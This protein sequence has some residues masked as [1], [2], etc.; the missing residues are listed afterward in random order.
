M[1]KM[2]LRSVAAIGAV[3]ALISPSFAAADMPCLLMCGFSVSGKHGPFL[4]QFDQAKLDADRAVA[5][6]AD[7]IARNQQTSKGLGAASIQRGEFYGE[8]LYMPRTQARLETVI[9]GLR[10]RWPYRD[11]GPVTVH[12]VGSTNFAP[13]ARPDNSIV[14]PLGFLVRSTTDDEVAWV[15]AHEYSHIAL[16][17]F[18][19][20][21]ELARRQREVDGF[22]NVLLLGLAL[23]QE[24]VDSTGQGVHF[25]AVNDPKVAKTSSEL[26]SKQLTVRT[27]LDLRSQ[28]VSRDQEDQA[29]ASGVDLAMGAGYAADDGSAHALDMIAADDARVGGVLQGLQSDL[30]KS[31]SQSISAQAINAAKSGN[32]GAAGEDFFNNLKANI[33]TIVGQKLIEYLSSSHRP[34]ESR[35]KGLGAYLTAA[36][37]NTPDVSEKTT[38][39][40]AVRADTEYVTAK[41][42]VE[43]HDQS[44]ID[45]DAGDAQKALSDL[46]AARRT[47]YAATPYVDDQAA[48]IYAALGDV[49]AADRLYNEA[50]SATPTRVATA[51]AGR[52]HSRHAGAGAGNAR[53]GYQPPRDIFLQ[54]SLV[55]Y[56]LHVALLAAHGSYDQARI[57]IAEAE[58]HFGDHQMFLPDLIYIDLKQGH[59]DDMLAAFDECHDTE[60]EILI[61]KCRYAIMD[62][63]T[64]K[65]VA[66]LSPA[67]RAKVDRALEHQDSELG[68]AGFMS[69]LKSVGSFV[70]PAKKA[71][72]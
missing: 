47:P 52:S 63:D 70:D 25:Y 9:A 31:M 23:S 41:T 15:L 10:A 50:E 4:K 24:R 62:E 35:R 29:D 67:E 13:L 8:G 36:Y 57:K 2:R 5:A 12:I 61:K 37:P 11:P 38:W 42:A 45:L 59:V 19:R 7:A 40:D 53:P 22:V 54:Q 1:V 66:S 32:I 6:K 44:Q 49:A 46:D 65:R 26:E 64:R 21:A 18:A 20:T 60:D 33:T 39:L 71:T 34:A 16:G 28:M 27:L 30:R 55:G 48:L 17:H 68:R 43:S 69:K 51:R 58:K 56:E 3:V 14:V 72:P